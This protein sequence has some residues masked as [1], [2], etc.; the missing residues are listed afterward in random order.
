MKDLRFTLLSDGSSDQVLVPILEWLLR[1]QGVSRP[2]Q[3]VWADLRRLRRPPETLSEKII[4]SVDLFPCDLLFIHRDAETMGLDSR[5]AEISQALAALPDLT[6]PAVCVIPI[7]MQEAWLLFEERALRRAAGNPNGQQPLIM[8]KL[9][10]LE[11][12]SNPK[13]MLYELLREASGLHGRRRKKF[14]VQTGA[15]RI[16]EFI[17]DF[18]P[19]LELRAFRELDSDLRQTVRV[20]DWGT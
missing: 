14:P 2:I 18:S 12:L 15:R 20:H 10:D 17:E 4:L 3:S 7:R 1:R 11:L 13:E 19:L 6:L 9:Q 5:K 8:P 16:V